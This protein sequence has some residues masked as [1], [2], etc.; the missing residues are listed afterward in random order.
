MIPK[1]QPVV[2]LIAEVSAEIILPRF[3]KLAAHEVSEKGPGDV[4]TIVDTE[5]EARMSARLQDLVPGSRVVGEEG[6]SA[7]PSVL[8]MLAGDDPVWIIDPLDGTQN[9]ANGIACFAVIIAY[10]VK[11]ET[12]AGWIGNPTA[13]SVSWAAR[14]EG[15]WA[16]GSAMRVATAPIPE[17][18]GS[19]GS[20]TR[21]YI[22]NLPTSAR[23]K[24]PTEFVRYACV[25]REYIDLAR[26]A[27]HFAQYAGRLKP[28]DHAAG[29]LLH[30]EAGGYGRMVKGKA[31][32]SA[33]Q[34]IFEG[35]LRMAPD[36]ASWNAL[37]SIFPDR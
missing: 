35:P 27:L 25:G 6:A 12:V 32:Y 29:V 7:D 20:K 26:G 21:R 24:A 16:N 36:E 22:E 1:I 30:A 13:G 3:R 11:G 17:M 10:C 33:A 9:F 28:W 14:G 15:A 23:A 4:V 34:G 8:A 37:H 19:V 18:V 31:A 2:D 5:S